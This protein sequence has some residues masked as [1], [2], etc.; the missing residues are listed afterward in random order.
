[1]T[2]TPLATLYTRVGCHLCEDALAT[3]RALQGRH[4]HTLEVVDV[5]DDPTLAARYG[6]S[7]PVLVVGGATIAAPLTRTILE[8]ALRDAR[9]P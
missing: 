1:M 7:V 8:R 4:P 5:D 3:L 2:G 9:Q 6:E